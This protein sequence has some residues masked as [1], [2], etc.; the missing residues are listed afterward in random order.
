MK[1]EIKYFN[2]RFYVTAIIF[3]SA[4]LLNAQGNYLFNQFTPLDFQIN[5]AKLV[6]NKNHTRPQC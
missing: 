6:N 5:P 3:N 2:F 4:I 1:K